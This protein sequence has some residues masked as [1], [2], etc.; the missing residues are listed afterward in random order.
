MKVKAAEGVLG[1]MGAASM[2]GNVVATWG[3]PTDMVIGAAF[4]VLIGLA[5]WLAHDK[6]ANGRLV[7]LAIFFATAAAMI[8][9]FTHLASLVDGTWM[10][11]LIP[12]TIDILFITAMQM[13][14]SGQ[15]KE[16]APAVETVE[17]VVEKIVEVQVPVYVER[18]PAPAPIHVEA[19][20]EETETVTETRQVTRTRRQSASMT[21]EQ[22]ERV[23]ELIAAN[24]EAIAAGTR[25]VAAEIM[26]K[27]ELDGHTNVITRMPEWKA[28]AG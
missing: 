14:L 27:V 26:R 24:R 18:E 20:V 10:R 2:A 22:R 6:R 13:V 4:P 15:K 21:A 28:I 8:W 19:Q 23:L 3:H 16:P 17:R 5:E 9:S 1:L 7:R 25:G 11:W 12:C